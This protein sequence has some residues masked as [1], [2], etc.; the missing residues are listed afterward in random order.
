MIWVADGN[1]IYTNYGDIEI[2]LKKWV[3]DI[4]NDYWEDWHK[5]IE[6]VPEKRTIE[7][8]V[9]IYPNGAVLS[10]ETEGEAIR[11]GRTNSLGIIKLSK[12]IT[13]ADGKV[14]EDELG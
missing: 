4:V 14:V 5:A 3:I 9:N 11:C 10:Y 8:W 6:I 7:I 12:E 1:P 13:I 2:V